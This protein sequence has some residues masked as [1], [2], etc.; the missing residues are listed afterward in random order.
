MLRAN[1]L[2]GTAAAALVV[3]AVWPWVQS[4]SAANPN[5]PASNTG[6]AAPAIAPLPPVARFAAIAERPLF[7]PSRRPV[8]GEK[9]APAG[10]GIEQRYHLLGLVTVGDTKRA[11]LSEGKRR[12]VIPEGALLEGWRV[13]IEHDRVVLTSSAGEAVLP[14]QPTAG[15]GWVNPAP[16]PNTALPNLPLPSVPPPEKP[17]A[18]KPER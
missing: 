7:S 2:L 8:P 12:L 13:H 1:H 15:E 18:P 3:L 14:M 5:R 4:P 6:A 9:A 17:A 16:L 11:L 10:P